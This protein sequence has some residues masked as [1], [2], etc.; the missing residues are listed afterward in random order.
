MCVTVPGEVVE[1]VHDNG[2]EQVQ[3]KEGANNEETLKQDTLVTEGLSSI[4]RHGC[5][6][7]AIYLRNV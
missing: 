2:H 7:I 4:S 6:N 5:K 3:D 1:V